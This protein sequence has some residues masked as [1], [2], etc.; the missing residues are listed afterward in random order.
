MT[1]HFSMMHGHAASALLLHARH[2]WTTQDLPAK[3]N[4]MTTDSEGNGVGPAVEIDEDLHSRQ[5]R[6]D[7]SS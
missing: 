2:D 3:R 4:K 7:A 5:V 6:G 1:L